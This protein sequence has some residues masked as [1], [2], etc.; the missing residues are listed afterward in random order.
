[1]EATRARFLRRALQSGVSI[2]IRPS[3][4]PRV[5]VDPRRFEQAFANIVDNAVRHTPSGGKVTLQA[6]ALN[7]SVR[8]AVH[9]SGSYI[10]PEARER[11]FERFYQADAARAEGSIGLGLAITR[12]IVDAHGGR[13]ELE[14]SEEGGTEFS[15]FVPLAGRE[16]ADERLA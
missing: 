12:E 13:V 15:I 4:A 1:M 7:G 8:F 11:I 14:S 3:A 9:N 16:G 10:P 2:E 6:E 5:K